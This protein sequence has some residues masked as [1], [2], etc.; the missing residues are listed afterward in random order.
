MAKGSARRSMFS[1][2]GWALLPFV[3][4]LSFWVLLRESGWI[5]PTSRSKAA[6]LPLCGVAVSRSKWRCSSAA[7]L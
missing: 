6:S 3:F 1:D 2:F 5:N 7:N 4:L